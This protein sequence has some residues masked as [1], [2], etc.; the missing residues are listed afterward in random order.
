MLKKK[1]L[2]EL[3]GR[4][5]ALVLALFLFVGG[6][7]LLW[8]LTLKIPDFDSYFEDRIIAEST[9][10]YDRTGEI[11]LYNAHDEVRRTIVSLENISDYAAKASIAIEDEDFYNHHG[12]Q[13]SAIIRAFIANLNAGEITQGGS[14]I[15][16]QVIKNTLLTQDKS[17]VRKIKE[18]ILA[19]KL[20]SKTSKDEILELYLNEV[21]YGGNIYGIEE[22]A[23]VFYGKAAKDL[24]LAE[25][26]YLA[27]LPQAPTTLSPYGNNLEKLERRKKKV[28]N[29]MYE[30]GFISE[31][32]YKT[33]EAEK[34]LFVKRENRGIKAP[35]FVFFVLEQ[36][37][38][39]YSDDELR[40]EG[41]RIITSLDW[42]LQ[43]EAEEIIT[44]YGTQNQQNYNADNAGMIVLDPKT[45][46][47][48]AMV[49]SIDY[50]DQDNDGNFN[51]TLAKR[52]PGS[53]FKPFV[54]ATAFNKGF[55]PETVVFDLPTEFNVNC[56]PGGVG[57]Q[58]YSPVNYDGS[59]AGPI[60]LR[61]ALAQSRN[62]PAV[63]ALYLAGLKDS[64]TTAR[65]MGISTLEN[66][67]RYGLTLVLGGGEVTLLDM[68]SAYSVFANEGVRNPYNPILEIKNSLG[69]T[70][71][72][73]EKD[74]TQ[75]LSPNVARTISD[76]LSD[77]SARAP[78]FGAGSQLVV[79]GKEVAV[80]TGTTN[81]YK[82]AWIVGYTPSIVV[83]AWV[84][85]N[86]NTPMDSRIAGVI[87]APIWNTFM[88]NYLS[89][90]P[91]ERFVDPEPT[92]SDLKPILNGKW[93]GSSFKVTDDEDNEKTETVSGVHSILYWVNKEN[94]RGPIPKN[95]DDDPQFSNWEYAVRAWAGNQQL[96]G[97]SEINFNSSEGI[98]MAVS[99]GNKPIDPTTQVAVA[100]SASSVESEVIDKVE[101]F[102]ENKSLGTKRNN[103]F[104]IIFTPSQ[105]L[106]DLKR[107][108]TIRAVVEKNDGSK[109]TLEVTLF[110]TVE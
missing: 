106:S 43:Q 95:P 7:G 23:R 2:I 13:P 94:P 79:P 78:I 96:G 83:G 52:Q 70:V 21:P 99:S 10:L 53:A 98:T 29:N 100:V 97:N 89:D 107:E 40:S 62:I 57:K 101:F 103:P 45:G 105:E 93:Q 109:T 20:E 34:V 47:V 64:F 90:K 25:S 110:L 33:A 4:L 50:F 71:K 102:Y 31:E 67:N 82:D 72:E 84:G 30:L 58:C 80:K 18:A 66:Y 77:D 9:K 39:E 69:E 3:F 73:Y 38:K 54:Y 59:S 74:Q 17:I 65:N 6:V 16:Q 91:S 11:V 15:T 87:V 61:N 48:L 12:V 63:K 41:L 81:D 35:H 88:R 55:T 37:E 51:V 104:V 24:S 92:P 14:T 108:N 28:L 27:S 60:T 42:E 1:K 56:S 46:D 26:A 36:L 76:I 44:R 49:G 8:M 5:T 85:N 75:V 86:D 68:T 19:F 32:E 22:A